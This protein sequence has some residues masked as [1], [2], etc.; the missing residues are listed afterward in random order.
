MILKFYM[1]STEILFP[2]HI[3]SNYTILRIYFRLPPE[4]GGMENHILHLSNEQRNLGYN[5]INIYIRLIIK[6]ITKFKI[7]EYIPTST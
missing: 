1:K 3:E 6:K 2:E 5:V 4:T 7:N